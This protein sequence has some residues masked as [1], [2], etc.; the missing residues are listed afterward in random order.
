MTPAPG[1]TREEERQAERLQRA[2]ASLAARHLDGSTEP[3]NEA[4]EEL[5]DRC[6]EDIGAAGMAPEAL[7][8]ACYRRLEDANE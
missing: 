4:A 7:V 2:L 3:S 1:L 5:A 8:N 6:W